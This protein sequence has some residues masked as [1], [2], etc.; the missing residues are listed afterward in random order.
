LKNSNSLV[1]IVHKNAVN[2]LVASLVTD[3]IRGLLRIEPV[4]ILQVP[5]EKRRALG[6]LGSQVLW[7]H[8]ENIGVRQRDGHLW[9]N[10][11]FRL[12]DSPTEGGRSWIIPRRAGCHDTSLVLFSEGNLQRAVAI[13]PLSSK[14][15]ANAGPRSGAQRPWTAV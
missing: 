4:V 13:W 10:S 9:T 6:P 5:D 1:A 8:A 7:K 14:A 3:G 2:A 12:G 11:L 15:L